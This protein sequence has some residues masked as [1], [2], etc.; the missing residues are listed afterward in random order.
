VVQGAYDEVEHP[1]ESVP[2]PA[3]KVLAMLQ[4]LRIESPG[5]LLDSRKRSL[6][7]DR[8]AELLENVL[9]TRARDPE[10]K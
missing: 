7:I 6:P 5:L 9:P 4:V 2:A 10:T 8:L 3:L 1:R